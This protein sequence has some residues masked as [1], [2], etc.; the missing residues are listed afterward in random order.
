MAQGFEALRTKNTT[1]GPSAC[2]HIGLHTH[3]HTNKHTH[4]ETQTQTQ[5]QTQAH[6]HT[7]ARAREHRHTRTHTHTHHACNVRTQCIQCLKCMCCNV[8]M[9]VSTAVCYYVCT[10][11]I[12]CKPVLMFS[13]LNLLM[14]PQEQCCSCCCCCCCLKHVFVGTVQATPGSREQ[15]KRHPVAFF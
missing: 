13:S 6:T 3:V 12:P 8:S 1:R 5:T 15:L 2:M 14:L 9:Y 4:T 11:V 10:H 7:H